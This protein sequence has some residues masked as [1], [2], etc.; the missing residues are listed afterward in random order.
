MGMGKGDGGSRGNTSSQT[1]VTDEWQCH[2]EAMS[3]TQERTVLWKPMENREIP[4]N[5]RILDH[6]WMGKKQLM[7][8]QATNFGYIHKILP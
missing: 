8:T 3:E 4:C 7:S 2:K 5:T 1:W 6:D